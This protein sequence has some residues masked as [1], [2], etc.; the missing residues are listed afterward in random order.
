MELGEVR[1]NE[2]VCTKKMS[3]KMTARNWIWVLKRIQ[4]KV[5]MST[6]LSKESVE[7]TL[8]VKCG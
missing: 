5:Q 8:R 4:N 6:G 3:V 1:G 2:N 7:W